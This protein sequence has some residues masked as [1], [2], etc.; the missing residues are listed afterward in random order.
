MRK[1]FLV[2]LSVVLFSF[3]NI[4]VA[5]S[6]ENPTTGIL[7][8]GSAHSN[9]TA[10]FKGITGGNPE[11]EAKMRSNFINCGWFDMKNGAGTTYV[12]S[13]K[14]AGNTLVITIANSAGESMN[15]IS[16]PISDSAS[17]TAA[18]AVDAVLKELFNIEGI[19]RSKIV[20]AAE[21]GK[22]Q[23]ELV[24]C[25]FDG[26]NRVQL[27]KYGTMSIEPSWTPDGKTVI[28]S[29]FSQ[30]STSL[31]QLNI[32]NNLV[33]RITRYKGINAGGAVS[34][35]GKH[36]ALILNR[37]NRVDLYIRSLE[38]GD[39]KR[40]TNNDSVEA[41]PVWSPDGR[42]ICFV[43]DSGG[44]PALYVISPFDARPAPQR[45]PG[46]DSERVAPDWSKDNK[47]VYTGK[48]GPNYVIRVVDMSSGAPVDVPV[49]MSSG[50]E[51]T[52]EGPSWAPDNRHVVVGDKGSIY[53]VDTRLGKKRLLLRGKNSL[54]QP[55]WSPII[56]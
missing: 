47:I 42:R 46:T 36:V 6:Q 34:P 56:K 33:R 41:S 26:N 25:D 22:V 13:G 20:F 2:F 28:F 7:I 52:G 45:I 21:S 53:V 10:Y 38:G 3:I 5:F 17:K 44:R 37:D 8:T 35:D 11:L 19:C 16:V 29:H 1:I 12:I 27:T 14:V 30:G 18:A 49:G 31:A 4:Y 24:M 55:D 50:M 15:S 9:P 23:R 32:A 40:I 39:L 51:I 54:S 43:S 48:S